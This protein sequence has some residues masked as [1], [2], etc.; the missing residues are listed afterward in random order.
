MILTS[1]KPQ[2]GAVPPPADLDCR[3]RSLFEH[4]WRLLADT[5]FLRLLPNSVIL[6][7]PPPPPSWCCSPRGRLQPRSLQVSR[8]RDA[9]VAG[10]VHLPAA[11]GGADHPALPDDGAAGAVEHAHELVLAHTTFALPYALWLLRS[12]MEGHPGGSGKRGAGRRRLAHGRI[13]RR[14]PAAAAAGHHLDRAVHLHPVVERI[15]LRTG[16]G[17]LRQ[18]SGR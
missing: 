3:K 12:F 8:T 11:V 13:P 14:D 10:A 16:A 18:R 7:P 6:S 1:V 15:P 9:G 4:Y 2:F 17:E 5:P